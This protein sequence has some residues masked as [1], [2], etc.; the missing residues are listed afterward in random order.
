MTVK[1][2]SIYAVIL[3][4]FIIFQSTFFYD[5]IKINGVGADFLLVIVVSIS[6]FIGP[7]RGEII[8]FITGFVVDII[9]GGLLG[10]S[11]FAYTVLGYGSGYFGRRIYSNYY[12]ISVFIVFISTFVKAIILTL[13]GAIF[14]KP[15]YFGFFTHGRVFLEAILNS[16]L[17]PLFFLIISKIEEKLTG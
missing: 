11:S 6:F 2:Y 12:V 4:F 14:I 7:L 9:S 15:G 10:I 8:G 16:I 13:I 3:A 1:R 17:A 5:S